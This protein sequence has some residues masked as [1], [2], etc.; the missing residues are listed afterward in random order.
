MDENGPPIMISN[1]ET[2]NMGKASNKRAKRTDDNNMLRVNQDA[3][4]VAS[5]HSSQKKR[6][7]QAQH[8]GQVQGGGIGSPSRTKVNLQRMKNNQ[9]N[10]NNETSNAGSN[11]NV[12]RQNQGSRFSNVMT[13]K[14][15]S[16]TPPLD[17]KSLERDNEHE[18]DNLDLA[19]RNDSADTR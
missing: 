1:F 8:S 6:A 13:L 3:T 16:P 10:R 2:S 14:P 18:F 5:A 4:N 15:P 19:R 12:S 9:V 7:A 17:P 11:Y